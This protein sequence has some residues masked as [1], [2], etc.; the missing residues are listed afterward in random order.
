MSTGQ[1]AGGPPRV[2]EIGSCKNF[3][4]T[5][6]GKVGKPVRRKG[7]S[8]FLRARPG[9][10]KKPTRRRRRSAAGEELEILLGSGLRWKY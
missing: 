4:E 9:I 5:L 10:F 6:E 7:Y 8:R 1:F 2:L 3:Q